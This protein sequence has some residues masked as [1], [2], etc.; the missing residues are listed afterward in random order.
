MRFKKN[1]EISLDFWVNL[2]RSH[3]YNHQFNVIYETNHSFNSV[4][5]GG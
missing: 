3:L 5:V 1:C 2:I 4:Y